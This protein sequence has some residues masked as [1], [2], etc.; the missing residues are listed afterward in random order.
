V[1]YSHT[2]GAACLLGAFRLSIALGGEGATPGRDLKRGL[3]I[4][5]LIGWAVVTEFPT[6]LPGAV[7]VIFS[8]ARAWAGGAKRLTRVASGIAVAGGACAVLLGAYHYA[9]FHDPFHVGYASEQQAVLKNGFFGL[10][11]P[12]ANIVWELL[13]GSFRG[14]LPLAPVLAL[15]PIGWSVWAWRGRSCSSCRVGLVAAVAFLLTFAMNASYEHWEGGWSFG[16]R[17]LG[18][19]LG[20]AAV[21]LVPVWM[22]GGR[23]GRAVVVVLALAGFGSALIGVSTTAQPPADFQAPM[24]EVLWPAFREGHVSLNRQSYFDERPDGAGRGVLDFD[25]PHAQWNLGEKMGLSGLVS[26]LPL[27]AGLVVIAGGALRTKD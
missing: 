21:A 10:T 1:F 4:G 2:L 9:A 3:G 7:I 14:I 12:K 6:A 24:R 23:I 17:Q 22:R 13:F 26:L 19:A 18:P 15:V 5:L 27:L 25:K 8:L 20:F 11:S 16:P